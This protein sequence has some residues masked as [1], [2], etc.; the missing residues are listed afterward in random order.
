M[1]IGALLFLAALVGCEAA[2]TFEWAAYIEAEDFDTQNGY[3]VEANKTAGGG[4]ACPRIIRAVAGGGRD[5]IRQLHVF[6]A[7]NRGAPH[8]VPGDAD[9]Q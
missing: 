8:L 6:C 9:E 5:A 4:A 3:T 1:R 7:G 2:P